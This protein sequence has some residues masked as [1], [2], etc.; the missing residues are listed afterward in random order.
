MQHFQLLM[1]DPK[2]LL[3]RPGKTLLLKAQSQTKLCRAQGLAHQLCHHDLYRVLL[4]PLGLGL[5]A[6]GV[7]PQEV[8]QLG[9]VCWLLAWEPLRRRRQ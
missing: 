9:E 1:R 7:S 4:V 6:S 5:H 8:R 3:G 2:R